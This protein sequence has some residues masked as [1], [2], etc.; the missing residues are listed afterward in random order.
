M[1]AR[2][3]KKRLKL[4][5]ARVW[6]PFILFLL[7]SVFL[8]AIIAISVSA[9]IQY[10]LDSKLSGIVD[11]GTKMVT[12]IDEGGSIVCLNTDQLVIADALDQ[13]VSKCKNM[14]LA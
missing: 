1:T 3:R 10:A 6:G 9:F 4:K 2:Q 8:T 14:R 11:T 12:A 13:I 7:M 5:K